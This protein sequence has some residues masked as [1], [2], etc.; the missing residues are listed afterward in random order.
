MKRGEGEKGRRFKTLELVKKRDGR[1]REEIGVGSDLGSQPHRPS[2]AKRAFRGMRGCCM[3]N[4]GLCIRMKFVMG[5][6]QRHCCTS[7]HVS[8]SGN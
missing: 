2:P 7:L 5:L 3:L 8:Q 1:K 6:L 4:L